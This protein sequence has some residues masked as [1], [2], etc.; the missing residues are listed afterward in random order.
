MMMRPA[1]VSAPIK[2]LQIPTGITVIF[3]GVA[4]G[5]HSYFHWI[6]QDYK[7]WAHGLKKAGYATNPKYP[8]ILIRSIE[9]YNLQ[10]YTLAGV[11]D[12]PKFESS[13]FKD[14][15]IA[16]DAMK[17][18]RAIIIIKSKVEKIQAFINQGEAGEDENE[19]LNTEGKVIFVNGNK[20]LFAKKGNIT[21]GNCNAA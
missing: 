8:N 12:V 15:P 5:T 21:I 19:V 18:S 20:C 9:Q 3:Y 6:L 16:F 4:N 2:M 1:N 14:D 13:K 7:G 17:R 10:Q 11:K